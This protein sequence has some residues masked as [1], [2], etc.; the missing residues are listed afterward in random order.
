MCVFCSI[1]NGDIPSKRVY[2]DEKMIIINDLNPQAKKHYL[3]IPKEHFPSILEMTDSQAELMKDNFQTLARLIPTLGLDGG[4]RLISN[5]GKD[6]RQ[7]VDHL[8]IHIVGGELLSDK[9]C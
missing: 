2:E 7:S 5:K 6:G 3:M 8:H 4:F 1:I 9:M